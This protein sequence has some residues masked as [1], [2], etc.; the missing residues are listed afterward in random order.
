MQSNLVE[1]EEKGWTALSSGVEES[2][3]FYESILSNQAVMLFP[4]GLYMNGKAEILK[5]LAAQPWKSFQIENLEVVSLSENSAVVI[6]KVTA[7]R[8]GTEPYKALIS[9]T[10]ALVNGDWKLFVHHQTLA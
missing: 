4:G 3:K 7:Q 10:Y 2:R 5:S 1:L 8:E 9:S 6:Y